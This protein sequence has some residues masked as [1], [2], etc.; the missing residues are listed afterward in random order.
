[1]TKIM[2][3]NFDEKDYEQIEEKYKYKNHHENETL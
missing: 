2:H 1:M 3:N